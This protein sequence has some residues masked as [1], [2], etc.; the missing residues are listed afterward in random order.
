[1]EQDLWVHIPGLL[2]AGCATFRNSFNLSIFP[3]LRGSMLTGLIWQPS[4]VSEGYIPK[5]PPT[6]QGMPEPK[7]HPKSH[8]LVLFFFSLN[9][10]LTTHC[11]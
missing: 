2:V 8:N 4:L 6:R 3:G 10:A 11:D 5:T 9:Q 7:G 1:M